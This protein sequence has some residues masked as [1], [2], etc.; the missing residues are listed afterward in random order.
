M[1]MCVFERKELR[2]RD[3]ESVTETS[4]IQSWRRFAMRVFRGFSLS[5]IPLLLCLIF[6]AL[7]HVRKREKNLL[8]SEYEKGDG[9]TIAPLEDVRRVRLCSICAKEWFPPIVEFIRIPRV[10]SNAI[11]REMAPIMCET[12]TGFESSQENYCPRLGHRRWHSWAPNLAVWSLKGSDKALIQTTWDATQIRSSRVI[13]AIMFRDPLIRF[14]SEFETSDKDKRNNLMRDLVSLEEDAFQSQYSHLFN[15]QTRTLL[16]EKDFQ[17]LGLT[18]SSQELDGPALQVI[19]RALERI[20]FVGL[21]EN[22]PLSLCLFSVTF[23]NTTETFQKYCEKVDMSRMAVN[24]REE[25]EK[26]DFHVYSR[27]ARYNLLDEMV[28]GMAR[29][30]FFD[31]IAALRGCH[32]LWDHLCTSD[33]SASEEYLLHRRRFQNELE[34]ESLYLNETKL[35][36]KLKS[37]PA[38]EFAPL[39]MAQH[40]KRC[41]KCGTKRLFHSYVHIHKNAGQTF[42]GIIVSEIC[43]NMTHAERQGICPHYP[44]LEEKPEI[45]EGV[46]PVVHN[47]RPA[48]EIVGRNVI[49]GVLIR[50][51][52]SRILSTHEYDICTFLILKHEF[53]H[54]S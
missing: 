31:R 32:P 10:A 8:L 22:V 51:P 21:A 37:S 52:I 39:E 16:G 27:V 50:D 7:T 20:H 49:K 29:S 25:I 46:Y 47:E 28:Y 26:Y 19:R 6:F 54:V 35:P 48:G 24:P 14:L 44:K 23:I 2:W 33:Q 13:K 53:T 9:S 38:H 4:F 5:A 36:K 11:I 42:T 41:R 12:R 40:F 45:L 18:P 30:I 15:K 1:D 3:T 34:D 43:P 17:A